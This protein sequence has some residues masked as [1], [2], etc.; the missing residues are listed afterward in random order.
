[1]LRAVTLAPLLL[2]VAFQALVT[3]WPLAKVHV[4]VQPLIAEP[5]AVTLTSAWKPPPH[6]PTTW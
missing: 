4:T 1:M 3:V 5:P 2:T 6:W